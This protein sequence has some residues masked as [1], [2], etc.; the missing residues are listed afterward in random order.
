MTDT[1]HQSP[2]YRNFASSADEK[3][4]RQPSEI[5]LPEFVTPAWLQNQYS[6]TLGDIRVLSKFLTEH[7]TEWPGELERS[8]EQFFANIYKLAAK[9]PYFLI[10]FSR[11]IEGVI[12]GK[13]SFSLANPDLRRKFHVERKIKKKCMLWNLLSDTKVSDINTYDP[14]ASSDDT[15]FSDNDWLRRPNG[16]EIMADISGRNVSEVCW[17]LNFHHMVELSWLD[18]SDIDSSVRRWVKTLDCMTDH[19]QGRHLIARLGAIPVGSN[20]TSLIS[21][22]YKELNRVKEKADS[23]LSNLQVKISALSSPSDLPYEGPIEQYLEIQMLEQLSE[24]ISSAIMIAEI[25][26]KMSDI[27]VPLVHALD[28]ISEQVSDDKKEQIDEYFREFISNIQY[29][30][31]FPGSLTTSCLEQV[32]IIENI[33]TWT[34]RFQSAVRDAAALYAKDPSPENYTGLT[35]AMS[36]INRPLEIEQLHD[37]LSS[38]GT[39]IQPF[40]N[41]GDLDED[42]L[43]LQAITAHWYKLAPHPGAGNGPGSDGI[44]ELELARENLD[45]TKA[46]LKVVMLQRDA[47]IDDLRRAREQ[48]DADRKLLNDELSKTR[49][50]L[51]RLNGLP[52]AAGSEMLPDKSSPAAN[53]IMCVLPKNPIYAKLPEWAAEHF[54][55]RIT[56]HSRALRALE[57]AQFENI[58]LVYRTVAVL[59]IYY[60]PMR[61]RDGDDPGIRETYMSAIQ[62]LFLDDTQSASESSMGMARDS[63]DIEWNGRKLTLDRHLKNRTRGRNPQRCFRLYFTWDDVSKTVLIGHLPG[64]LRT[65]AN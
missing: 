12:T 24:T 33:A 40:M 45:K 65:R 36:D 19:W 64:H 13:N 41:M 53:G 58:E 8:P 20:L 17:I 57:D 50:E 37:A 26:Q 16:C 3:Y 46:E 35:V 38:I 29:P 44:D 62:N 31:T 23:F 59:G 25:R 61:M 9:W 21:A 42:I 60:W 18:N 6:L 11:M 10:E 39:Q 22:S 43:R 54:E 14:L 63:Y 27:I 49:G 30:R 4:R 32:K 47:A 56:F 34:E 7:Y 28:S 15:E 2:R 48:F 1:R 51:R 55:K 52:D 5:P